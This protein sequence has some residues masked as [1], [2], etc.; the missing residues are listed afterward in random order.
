MKA[1]QSAGRKQT[2]C[3]FKINTL[4]LICKF[5]MF[6]IVYGQGTVTQI[7]LKE[8]TFFN[9]SNN[10]IKIQF[11]ATSNLLDAALNSINAINSLVK[12]ENYR[13]KISSFNNPATADL[14]FSLES[15][16]TLALRPILEKTKKTN[17]HKFS[18]IISSLIRTP[19]KNQMPG[20]IF[21]A[22]TV[23][24]SLL[25]LVGNLAINE[26][27]VTREDVDT[28]I[29]NTS[30]YF[31]QYEKLN[32]ANISFDGNVEK[33]NLKL[34]ELQFDTREF[35]IDMVTLLYTNKTRQELKQRSL[36]ELLLKFLDKDIL[37]TSFDNRRFL[38]EKQIIYYPGD[39]IKT[40]KEIVYGIQKLFNEYQKIYTQ[41][42]NEIR[43][44]L[45]QTKELGK[46][47]NIKQ[48]DQA[49]HEFEQ[50][51]S[52]SKEADIV[53]LRLN[54]LFERLKYLDSTENMTNAR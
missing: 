30:K 49:V 1:Y 11:I 23:F 43:T 37:D 31:V 28:F 46:N 45:L 7:E 16:I 26:K 14:G 32:D 22:G 9:T 44:V 51:F 10:Q 38:T 6:S 39:G 21:N 20:S 3:T 48:V 36:E 18:E 5:L 47:I 15:E 4:I 34:Q 19:G 27:K 33:F 29:Y 8:N 25:S 53:N 50:L 17:T 24:N 35:M 54:T 40:A 2:M 52:E 13:N 42:Y 12:K 41:N